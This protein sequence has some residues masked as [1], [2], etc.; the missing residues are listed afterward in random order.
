MIRH[1]LF[2]LKSEIVGRALEEKSRAMI[3]H[4]KELDRPA[5][6]ELSADPSAGL[7]TGFDI[8]AVR[9]ESFDYAQDRLVEACGEFHRTRN[10]WDAQDRPFDWLRVNGICTEALHALE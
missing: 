4:S 2:Q 1:S 3:Q 8:P 10:G 5:S 9:P 6:T 7:R